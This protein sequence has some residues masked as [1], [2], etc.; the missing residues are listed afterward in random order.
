MFQ[1]FSKALK[2]I[3]E[4]K[5]ISEEKIMEAIEIALITAYRKDFGN[6]NQEV[7]VELDGMSLD[8]A[9]VFLIKEVVEE[10]EDDDLEVSLEEAKKL[11][12]EV[13]EGDEVRIDVTPNEYGRIATQAAKQVILQRIQEAE[14]ESLYELFKD[15]EDSLINAMVNRVEGTSVYLD[16]DKSTVFLGHRHQIPGETYFPGRRITVYLDKVQQT[17]KGPQLSISRTNPRLIYKLLEREIPEVASG[18]VVIKE[19]ARD[20]G[21]RSKVA[22]SSKDS[23]LD[24]VGA[25]VG[26]KGMRINT[27]TDELNGERI[28]MIEWSDKTEVFIARALQP[29]KIAHVIVVN[30]EEGQDASGKRV[31]KRAAVFV[32]EAERAMAIGRKGQNIQLAT[33]LTGFEL[34]MYNIEEFESFMER[35]NELRED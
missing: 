23:S 12:E 3:A 9:K 20:A 4:E 15:R 27:V 30:S 5:N 7:E 28:D 10:V 35:L 14:K 21:A 13:E 31:K 17:A 24:P 16:V 2:M 22:V 29:A 18:D 26:Q 34:D 6:K 11:S 32:E 19:V 1:D 8:G 33:D 25:C